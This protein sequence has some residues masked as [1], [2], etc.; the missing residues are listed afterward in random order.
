MTIPILY[1]ESTD[2]IGWAIRCEQS[3]EDTAADIADFAEQY[4]SGDR[5]ALDD[6]GEVVK[7]TT[8]TF[9]QATEYARQELLEG[10]WGRDGWTVSWVSLSADFEITYTGDREQMHLFPTAHLAVQFAEALAADGSDEKMEVWGI[11][12]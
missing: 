8:L 6:E 12:R 2:I 7:Y 10:D 11:V 3:D 9:A 4:M 1:A 5:E